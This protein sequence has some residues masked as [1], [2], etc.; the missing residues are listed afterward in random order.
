MTVT[1]VNVKFYFKNI[2]YALLGVVVAV[3]GIVAVGFW[4]D[5]FELHPIYRTIALSGFIGIDLY[6][7]IVPIIIAIISAA[8]FI[9]N[10]K[11][12]AKKFT[13][14]FLLSFVLA[15][16]LCHPT[17]EGLSGAPLLFALVTSSVVTAVIVYPKPFAELKKDFVFS[18][19]LNLICVPLSLLL[20]D[21]VYLPYFGSSVIGGGG[22]SDGVLLST[23]YTPFSVTV[24]FSAL[25]Y[26]SQIVRLVRKN[27]IPIH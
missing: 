13:A 27:R 6:G 26:L 22:F 20:V 16:V 23:L 21:V 18:L 19:L 5:Y 1:T 11:A 14:S 17:D 4:G 24:V 2:L 25:V 15:F 7:A 9:K 10:M 3:I 12:Y 8:L